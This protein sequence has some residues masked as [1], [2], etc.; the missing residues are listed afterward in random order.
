M[1]EHVSTVWW[2]RPEWTH[3]IPDGCHSV[4]IGALEPTPEELLAEEDSTQ[5]HAHD[6]EEYRGPPHLEAVLANRRLRVAT[7]LQYWCDDH[8]CIADPARMNP[9]AEFTVLVSTAASPATTNSAPAAIA[10][11]SAPPAAQIGSAEALASSCNSDF[12]PSNSPHNPEDW[13]ERI[14]S[15]AAKV[16][17]CD[18]WV[19]DICLDYFG[20]HNP[21]A[22]QLAS[23]GG[24]RLAAALQA[25]AAGARKRGAIESMSK[26]AG[27]RG[28]AEASANAPVD[29]REA[30]RW[31][32]EGLTNVLR[33]LNQPT[34]AHA[35]SPRGSTPEDDE[36]GEVQNDT[37]YKRLLCLY[38]S[39][40]EGE[41][42]VETLA[43]EATA[44]SKAPQGGVL[45]DLALAMVPCACLPDVPGTGAE[46]HIYLQNL[47]TFLRMPA[48]Q[49]LG[50]P[51]AVTLARSS[52]DPF[53]PPERLRWL[54]AQVKELVLELYGYGGT[55]Y[56]PTLPS[57]YYG[58]PPV[59]IARKSVAAA[60]MNENAGN[61][62][63]TSQAAAQKKQRQSETTLTS[64]KNVDEMFTNWLEEYD[65][66][67]N[68][69]LKRKHVPLPVEL[70]LP[71]PD[72]F[73]RTVGGSD[74]NS[75]SEGDGVG[76][77]IC[78]GAGDG[79]GPASTNVDGIFHSCNAPALLS[80]CRAGALLKAKAWS[81]LHPNKPD[82]ST[83]TSSL[84]T[85]KDAHT[86]WVCPA[87]VEA[88]A[89]SAVQNQ[90]TTSSSRSSSLASQER[91]PMQ[92]DEMN[93]CVVYA[94]MSQLLADAVE[95]WAHSG[96]VNSE[97]SDSRNT[98]SSE[99]ASSG[100]AETLHDASTG[101]SGLSVHSGCTRWVF[102]DGT[103]FGAQAK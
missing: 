31:L 99:G 19:L 51:C 14:T 69:R 22:F 88:N 20:T 49:Q 90:S 42:L 72:H 26:N 73:A 87:S 60:N 47:R 57:G 75:S 100:T 80:M 27:E 65:D 8:W 32:E 5:S 95:W 24:H 89:M 7:E 98:E 63:E 102:P 1:A 34:K 58:A 9:K 4:T 46:T 28:V 18:G 36:G 83:S 6:P 15:H 96:V 97:T 77:S 50:L 54:E 64:V 68:R 33:E 93:G 92:G 66:I 41:T 76:D 61:S 23:R 79:R 85:P 45:L 81:M 53:T 30:A 52:G 11:V 40:D 82:S 70:G 74:G 86:W 55:P 94:N 43:A 103:L 12:I 84:Q 39:R 78:I 62:T 13:N 37:F 101:S 2:V 44:A 38:A 91:Q 17:A 35:S 56:V 25:A 16:Q 10:S 71:V 67:N 48:M 29:K 3:D 59:A 21:F